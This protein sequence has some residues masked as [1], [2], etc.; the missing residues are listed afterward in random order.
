MWFPFMAHII[1][2]LDSTALSRKKKK[3]KK[4]KYIHTRTLV[5]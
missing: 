5:Y 4:Q 3:N 1:F 2:L